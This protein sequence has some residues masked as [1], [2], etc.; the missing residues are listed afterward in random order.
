[1]RPVHENDG[2]GQAELEDGADAVVRGVKRYYSVVAGVLSL[3]VRPWIAISL[4]RLAAF[5]VA[6]VL[7]GGFLGQGYLVLRLS[8]LVFLGLSRGLWL[9]VLLSFC[10]GWRLLAVEEVIRLARLRIVVLLLRGLRC[11][12]LGL[13][14]RSSFCCFGSGPRC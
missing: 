5:A 14:R 6:L 11:L 2:V 7:L 13:L 3:A 10:L 9:L 1:M 4:F 8:T 12:G